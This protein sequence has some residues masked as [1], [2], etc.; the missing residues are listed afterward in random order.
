MAIKITI[1]PHR[2]GKVEFDQFQ[3]FIGARVIGY[4]GKAADCRPKLVVKDLSD[5]ILAEVNEACHAKL[6]ELHPD[7]AGQAP[8]EALI[9]GGV[10]NKP[11]PQPPLPPADP[12][13][14][15]ALEAG[16]Q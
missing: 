12:A 8:A 3:V 4:L 15:A 5:E 16:L 1:V 2:V 10:N 9:A 7:L 13:D 6:V 11:K 14:S